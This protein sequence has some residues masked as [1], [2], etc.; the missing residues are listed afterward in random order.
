MTTIRTVT[1]EEMKQK[2]NDFSQ[3]ILGTKLDKTHVAVISDRTPSKISVIENSDFLSILKEKG[4][5]IP[6]SMEDIAVVSVVGTTQKN[7][8]SK[9]MKR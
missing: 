4:F 9:K 3:N 5:A 1:Q 2:F 6:E 7:T 8:T